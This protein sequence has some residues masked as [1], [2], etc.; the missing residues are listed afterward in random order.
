[1]NKQGYL[2]VLLIV[3]FITSCSDERENIVVKEKDLIE[4]VYSSVRIEPADYYTV[5]S[6][7]SGYLNDFII[8]EGDVVQ[9]GEVLFSV[10]DVSGS[11]TEQNAL[12][13]YDLAKTN[14]FGDRSILNDMRFEIDNLK[15]KRKNDS[16]N[17][18]R[19]RSLYEAGGVTKVELEQSELLFESSRSAHVAAQN[20]YKRTE[21]EMKA[22]M[23]QA[24]NNYALSVS[25][26]GD[27][28]I[29]S[30]ISGKVYS[31]LKEKGDLVT[32]QEPLAIVGSANEFRILLMVDEL[33]INRIEVGQKIF[34][35]LE[36]YPGK[37]FEA[38]ID[39]IVPKLDQQTQTFEVHA[40]FTKAPKQLYMGLTGEASIVIE[41]RQKAITIP[42]EYLT[43]KNEVETDDG[44]VKVKTGIKSLSEVEIVDGLKSGQRIYRPEL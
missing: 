31:I 22:A 27:A 21:L 13:A 26:S 23:E 28:R 29:T 19:N 2:F 39:R 33:D 7:V 24:K 20:R 11:N 3:L 14:L 10:R 8:R 44:L 41:E 5:K 1:M 43:D 35:D 34:V 6:T 9:F 30:A 32:I 12:V 37:V 15:L 16:L 40:K 38:K 17:Y 18:Y 4:A 25:R 42:R 36:S